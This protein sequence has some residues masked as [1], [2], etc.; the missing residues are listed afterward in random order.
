MLNNKLNVHRD[1]IPAAVA[2]QK[3]DIPRKGTSPSSLLERRGGIGG[4]GTCPLRHRPSYFVFHMT[5]ALE[6]DRKS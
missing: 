6:F 5:Y 2:P 1:F 4:K 3:C